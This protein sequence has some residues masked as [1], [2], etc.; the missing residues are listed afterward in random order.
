MILGKPG[1]HEN[2]L[3]Q[4]RQARGKTV[5]F[6]TAV[7]VMR[8]ADDVCL[9]EEVPFEV[10]FRRLSETQLEKYLR[11][12]EPYDCAGSFKAEGFGVCL[13]E[14]L[15]GDDPNALIG[16]PLLKLITMLEKAGVE[17]I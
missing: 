15:R 10:E 17:V 9:V 8:Q 3:R 14:A 6:H 11:V 4:L 16:L 2:A 5:F 7:C 13:F 12:E 1:S